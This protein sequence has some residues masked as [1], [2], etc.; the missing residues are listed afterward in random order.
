M[1][2]YTIRVLGCSDGGERSGGALTKA[3]VQGG[4]A[5]VCCLPGEALSHGTDGDLVWV[6]ANFRF[7]RSS[8]LKAM[9]VWNITSMDGP[10]T[11]PSMDWLG[12]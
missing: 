4:L 8:R 11:T 7:R 5:A 6:Q 9:Q 12:S 3:L 2:E 1:P 10:V